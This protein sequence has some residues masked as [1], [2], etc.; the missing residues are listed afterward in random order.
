MRGDGCA[1]EAD[2]AR[3]R[4]L[5]MAISYGAIFDRPDPG[6]PAANAGVQADDV[7]TSINGSPVMLSSDVAAMISAMALSQHISQRSNDQ[8][9]PNS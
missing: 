4:R 8:G 9:Q 2:D 5:G 7:L 1:G 6:G 3:V